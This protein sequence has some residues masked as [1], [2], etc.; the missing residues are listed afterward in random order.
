MKEQ[1]FDEIMSMI[2]ESC[3]KK[4]YKG[5]DYDGL[6]LEIVRCATEIYVEQMR[7]IGVCKDENT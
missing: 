6:K 4:F 7:Q 1:T 3:I 5:T 2:R